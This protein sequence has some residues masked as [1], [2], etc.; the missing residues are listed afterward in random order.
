MVVQRTYIDIGKDDTM[1]SA[2]AQINAAF[3]NQS[4]FETISMCEL[5]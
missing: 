1:I 3:Y 5:I 4:L 2:L